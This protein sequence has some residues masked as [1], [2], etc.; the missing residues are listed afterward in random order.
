MSLIAIGVVIIWSRRKKP[1]EDESEK[2]E[3]DKTLDAVK[4]TVLETGL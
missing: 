4:N 2:D 1:E 3:L